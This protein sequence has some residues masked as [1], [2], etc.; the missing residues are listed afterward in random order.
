MTLPGKEVTD[1]FEKM[2]EDMNLNEEHNAPLRDKDLS[3]KH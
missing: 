2:V 1:L 3:T